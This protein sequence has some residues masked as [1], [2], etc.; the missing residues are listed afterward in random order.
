MGLVFPTSGVYRD[1]RRL[2]AARE[3]LEGPEYERA[4]V[5]LEHGL[6]NL[7]SEDWTHADAR[8]L[9]K[10]AFKCS[11]QALTF[12]WHGDVDLDNNARARA[13]GPAVMIRK[14]SYANQSQRGAW[15]QSV[16]IPSSALCACENFRQSTRSCRLRRQ[17]PKPPSVG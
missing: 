8:R 13:I 5:R 2:R 14:N 7:G 1:A 6:I 3:E 9:A 16:L 10:R 11:S 17:L 12:L 4:I 15:T